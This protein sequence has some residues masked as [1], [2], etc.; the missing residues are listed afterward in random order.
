[1]ECAG[2]REERVPIIERPPW[3]VQEMEETVLIIERPPW[4][5]QEMEETV[6]I[7]EKYRGRETP[8]S[9]Q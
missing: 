1:M 5:I 8:P 2:D 4:S 6:P 3:S 9:Q 7:I